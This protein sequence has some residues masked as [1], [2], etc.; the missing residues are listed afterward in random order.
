MVPA[1]RRVTC[2]VPRA[3]LT[4]QPARSS[5]S[6]PPVGAQRPASARRQPQPVVDEPLEQPGQPV[7]GSQPQ[8]PLDGRPGDRAVATD[9]GHVRR[10][11]AHRCRLAR[12]TRRA[13]TGTGRAGG[14]AGRRARRPGRRASPGLRP[15]IAAAPRR[16]CRPTSAGRPQR[17][18][19]LESI[20]GGRTPGHQPRDRARR[21]TAMSRQAERQVGNR[22]GGRGRPSSPSPGSPGVEHRAPRPRRSGG[23]GDDPASAAARRSRAAT[24]RHRHG[25]RRDQ[26]LDGVARAQRRASQGDVLG[27]ARARRPGRAARH[28][29]AG[30]TARSRSASSVGRR[31]PPRRRATSMPGPLELLDE[32]AAAP[33]LAGVGF[34]LVADDDDRGR[35]VAHERPDE[36]GHGLVDVLLGREV[37]A[38]HQAR[39]VARAGRRPRRC[40]AGGSRAGRAGSRRRRR[41]RGG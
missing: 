31:G 12:G 11:R 13:P 21:A 14:G 38:G 37:G 25:L 4:R 39:P 28:P 9:P 30:S 7:A 34:V 41:A 27:D 32:G 3:E 8:G 16:R 1:T 10:H 19:T 5:G 22:A 33:G 18:I 20:L 2:G 15:A 17:D 24:P 26:P 29:R 36:G 40:R 35:A 6:A 23:G